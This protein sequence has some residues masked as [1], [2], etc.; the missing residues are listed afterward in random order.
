MEND[1]NTAREMKEEGRREGGEQVS[2]VSKAPLFP[3]ETHEGRY[4][5]K[6][7][8]DGE[9]D[10]TLHCTAPCSSLT[11]GVLLQPLSSLFFT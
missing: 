2:E 5:K 9:R 3:S 7:D 10:C 4:L 6:R 11:L 8:G 1:R